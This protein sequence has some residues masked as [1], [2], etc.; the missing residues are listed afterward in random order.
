AAFP[1]ANKDKTFAGVALQ[2]Q[3]VGSVRAT[4]YFLM[5]A[6]SLVLLIACA[7]I[8]NLL[9]ARAT[10][11]QREMAVRAALGASRAAIARQLFVES[12]VIALAGGGLGLV[13]ASVGTRALTTATAQQ[14]GLPRLADIQVNWAVFGFALGVS[15]LASFLFGLSPAW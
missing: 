14:V 1:D 4:L 6:V 2:E 13:L 3:L 11:R 10:A 5:G 7:N 8:A 9:L 12:G 15:L